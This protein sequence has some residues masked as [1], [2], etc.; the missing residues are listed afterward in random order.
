MP[1]LFI[2]TGPNG[3]GKSSNARNFLPKSVDL[4]VFDGD[5]LFYELLNYYYKTTKVNKYAKEKATLVLK[6]LN[7]HFSELQEEFHKVVIMCLLQT[8]L[9]ITLV[10]S[11]CLTHILI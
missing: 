6:V 5:K 10:T 3:A 8:F 7:Y 2:I 11:E 4:P 1:E 9:T